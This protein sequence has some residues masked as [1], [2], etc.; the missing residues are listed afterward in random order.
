VLE[1]SSYWK[2][3]PVGCVQQTETLRQSFNIM[4]G[5]GLFDMLKYS[6]SLNRVYGTY[7]SILC[8]KPSFLNKNDKFSQG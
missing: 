5:K 8:A 1:K 7:S 4:I 6:M 2:L 3:G